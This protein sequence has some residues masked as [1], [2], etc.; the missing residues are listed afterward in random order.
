MTATVEVLP[1]AYS[2]DRFAATVVLDGD[3]VTTFTCPHG[4]QTERTAARCVDQTRK[5]WDWFHSGTDV[6]ERAVG[7]TADGDVLFEVSRPD[8]RDGRF[9]T[10]VVS[11]SRR[12]SVRL[13]CQH[14]DDDPGTHWVDDHRDGTEIR[15][16][17]GCPCPDCREY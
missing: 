1:A 5:A 17:C 8:S 3:V 9:G 11:V 2:P 13:R 12:Y 7:K 16:D 14:T 6:V 10:S 4:H 15:V